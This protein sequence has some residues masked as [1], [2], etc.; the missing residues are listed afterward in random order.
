ML[1]IGQLPQATGK[2]QDLI[3]PAG[4][5]I[6]GRV[7]LFKDTKME[8]SASL[9]LVASL[10]QIYLCLSPASAAPRLP[11]SREGIIFKYG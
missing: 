11:V 7:T 2:K 10:S 5:R 4:I 3:I 1:W 8:W 6:Q 9:K